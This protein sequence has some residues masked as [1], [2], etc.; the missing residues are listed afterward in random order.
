MGIA[1]G[2]LVLLDRDPLSVVLE[3]LIERARVL[4]IDQAE[5][6]EQC[7]AG[8]ELGVAAAAVA[9]G[10]RR[11][12]QDQGI[13]P[14]A[15][16]GLV[17]DMPDQVQVIVEDPRAGA[18]G[19]REC[20]EHVHRLRPRRTAAEGG[21]VRARRGQLAN[22]VPQVA[23]GPRDAGQERAEQRRPPDR[24]QLGR[25]LA[26]RAHPRLPGLP[27]QPLHRL[28]TGLK[29]QVHGQ[30][31]VAVDHGHK[32]TRVMGGLQRGRHML[33]A[34]H[35]PARHPVKLALIQVRVNELHALRQLIRQ[36]P[37]GLPQ[38]GKV[39]TVRPADLLPQ[40]PLDH[41]ADIAAA[42][43]KADE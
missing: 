32:L 33:R 10:E 3:V 9:L 23:H 21:Q 28:R 17:K 6:V 42:A 2:L 19:H 4:V 13:D 31:L 29:T 5:Q 41:R 7:P 36:H 39:R 11:R 38:P 30:F 35:D 27:R 24:R 22:G 34:Q 1:N 12:H 16:L 37:G 20:H 15:E 8:V 40:P 26:Q 43:T 14:G 25:A 18:A